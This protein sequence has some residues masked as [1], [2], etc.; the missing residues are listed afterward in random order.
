MQRMRWI[1]AAAMLVMSASNEAAGQVGAMPSGP[2][3]LYGVTV[4]AVDNVPAV[5]DALSHL[6][7]T[8]RCAS[9]LMKAWTRRITSGP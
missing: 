5:V 7:R 6:S 4:D 1:L 2:V 3:P 9:S 8:P